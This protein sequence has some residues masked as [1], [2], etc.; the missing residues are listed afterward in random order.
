VYGLIQAPTEGWLAPVTLGTFGFAAL[1]LLAFVL[2]ELHTDEP[3]LDIRFFRNASFSV[4]S[5]GMTLVFLAM[6]GVM[7]LMTQYFQLVL[8]YSPL[9]A[10]L[11]LLPMAPIMIV[12]APLTP[13]LSQRFGSNRLVG[14]GM[15]LV[16]FGFLIFSAV[17]LDTPYWYFLCALLPLVS[18][19]ALAMSPM[20]AAIMSAVPT[21]R[22]GAGSAMNDATRE[23]G[24]A[25][26]VAVLGSI[27]ASQYGSN[28][29]HSLG[30]LPPSARSEASASIAGALHAAAQLTGPAAAAFTH[31]AR[32]AFVDGIH[33]AALF[34]VVL[35]GIA[36]VL[37]TRLLPRSLGSDSALHSATDALEDVVEL[38]LGGVTPV[39]GDEVANP[40]PARS[41]RTLT[42]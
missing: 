42:S 30:A 15:G 12:V 29:H 20:T 7:F 25:L 31:A 8:G 23:L 33:V 13:R 18:G 41:S 3:M 36:A 28:L 19:M 38:G 9:S 21:R 27:A 34:G 26:G 17:G 10:A 11:R 22:A 32:V 2:W 40:A 6:F 39:F 14:F 5:G 1:V 24:A 37:T 35:A 4:G 16:A